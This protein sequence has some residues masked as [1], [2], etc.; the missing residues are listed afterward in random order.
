MTYIHDIKNIYINYMGAE[1]K[2]GWLSSKQGVDCLLAKELCV[3]NILRWIEMKHI[4]VIPI[5]FT[6]YTVLSSVSYFIKNLPCI[7]SVK[8]TRIIGIRR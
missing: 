8:P 7:A 2:E 5:A 1:H 3:L 6:Q 4:C